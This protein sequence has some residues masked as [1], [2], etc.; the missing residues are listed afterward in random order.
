V[1]SVR[2]EHGFDIPEDVILHSHRREI[3][4]SYN[5]SLVKKF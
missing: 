2:Y 5:V 1:F 3:L 4:K